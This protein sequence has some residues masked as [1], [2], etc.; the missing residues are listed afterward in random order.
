LKLLNRNNAKQRLA[1]EGQSLRY[2]R[3]KFRGP[4]Q[5][6]FFAISLSACMLKTKNL[7]KSLPCNSDDESRDGKLI[8]NNFQC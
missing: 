5:G 2:V 7:E 3:G 6:N 1:E 4:L 8:N